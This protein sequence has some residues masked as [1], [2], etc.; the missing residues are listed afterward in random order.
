MEFEVEHYPNRHLPWR[1][2][3]VGTRVVYSGDS[4]WHC[5]AKY[6]LCPPDYDEDRHW[7]D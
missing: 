4:L 7:T 6:T 1:I 3:E 5:L 2:N